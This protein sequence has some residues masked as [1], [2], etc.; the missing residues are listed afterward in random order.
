[1]KKVIKFKPKGM[2][3]DLSKANFSPEFS[4]ENKNIR[5]TTN[6]ANSLM[7]ITNE[8]G[9]LKITVKDTTDTEVSFGTIIGS[10]VINNELILFY[11]NSGYDYI[12]VLEKEDDAN[13]TL[14]KSFKGKLGFD[15]AYPI[16]TISVYE[17]NNTQKIYWTDGFNQPRVI[18]IKEGVEGDNP[19]SSEEIDF[20]PAISF[21]EKVKIANIGS[22]GS[23]PAGTIQYAFTYYNKNGAESNIVYISPLQYI[24]HKNRGASAED[25]VDTSFNIEIVDDTPSKYDYVR[26]YSIHRTSINSTPMCKRVIDLKIHNSPFWEKQEEKTVDTNRHVITV[27]KISFISKSDKEYKM[28]DYFEYTDI[29]EL[30]DQTILLG[31]EGEDKY[32]LK[33]ITF[34]KEEEGN[35]KISFTDLSNVASIEVFSTF[36]IKLM[37]ENNEEAS[38]TETSYREKYK[39]SYTDKGDSGDSIDPMELLYV[40]GESVIA[41]TIS[42]K[43]NTLFLG[44][45]QKKNTSLDKE[46]LEEIR[47]DAETYPLEF[48]TFKSSKTTADD[49]YY[50]H[51]NTL[52]DDISKI[53]TFKQREWYRFGIQL[54]SKDGKWSNPIFLADA[55]NDKNIEYNLSYAYLIN[56]RWNLKSTF[57]STFKRSGY[58]RVR[59]V[60]VYP[61]INERECICQGV[62]APTVYNVDDRVSNSPFVQSSWVFRPN[63]EDFVY[64]NGIRSS[65]IHGNGLFTYSYF[66]DASIS[67]PNSIIN[68]DN[69]EIQACAYSPMFPQIAELNEIDNWITN[70][71]E[72]YFVDRSIFTM[73][74]PDLEFEDTLWNIDFSN[75]KFRIIGIV[76]IESNYSDINIET[77][78]LPL[79]VDDV[80]APGYVKLPMQVS[81]S[82]GDGGGGIVSTYSWRDGNS[83]DS[84]DTALKDYS[85]HLWHRSGSLNNAAKKDEDGYRSAELKKKKTSILRYSTHTK[86]LD[87]I[88]EPSN[89]ISG[90]SLYNNSELGLV[91]VPS[92]KN[93][94]LPDIIYYGN[95]DKIVNITKTDYKYHNIEYDY[96]GNLITS[97]LYRVRN[98]G[99]P[100][101]YKDGPFNDDNFKGLDPVNIKYKSSPHAIIALNYSEDGGVNVL[102]YKYTA[103]HPKNAYNFWNK[104]TSK[105][106]SSNIEVPN[107]IKSYL[108]LGELYRDNIENRFGGTSEDALANNNWLP[109]GDPVLLDATNDLEIVWSVGDT[110]YQRYDCLKTYPFTFEDTNQLTDILSFMC[111]TRVN[112]DGRYDRNRGR[113]VNNTVTPSNFNLINPIY[114]QQDNFFNYR[115][116]EEETDNIYPNI[117]TWSKTK[118]FGEKVDTWTNITLASTLDLDGDKGPITALRRFNNQIIAFQH[119]GISHILYNENTQ[120]STESGVPIEIANSGKVSGKRYIS[121][122]VG[123]SNKQSICNSS[124]GLY[125][126]DSINK[127]INLFNG[128]SLSSLSRNLGFKSWIANHAN[129]NIWTKYDTLNNDILFIDQNTCL[130][131]S[132][133]LGQFT[134]FYDYNDVKSVLNVG[135]D[136]LLIKDN[137]LYNHNKGLYNNFFNSYKP[138][139]IE[140]IANENPTLD[141]IFTNI[142]FTSDTWNSN[143]DLLG[144]TFDTLTVHNEYQQGSADLLFTK[145]K[146]SPL[147][148]KFRIWRADIPRDS[149][150]NRDRMRNTWLNLKLEKSNADNNSDKTVLHDLS[151]YYHI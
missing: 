70:N 140:V 33:E 80:V 22:G 113:L 61:S 53:T 63:N 38:V 43:D 134:S 20:V 131:Y 83:A 68:P 26:I 35:L 62:V 138:F 150:N 17:N 34:V 86:Y 85:V 119:T 145:N 111:E 143:N 133:S 137:V 89:G 118:V 116:V 25:V 72:Y 120:I 41:Q 81:K 79:T 16:E 45:I 101:T 96:E 23:F 29:K 82:S 12:S 132:E 48:F 112:I 147:K 1:M 65:W 108:L 106:N 27:D 10:T 146:P 115:I 7:S 127:E 6:E 66:H 98:N 91:T 126:I 77:S 114:T 69:R 36:K 149:T 37:T 97:E 151:V 58:T 124:N 49:S 60:I 102:P 73:H 100:I 93:S 56:A 64:Y 8:K 5:F 128:E 92:P 59:P 39:T 54:Q 75:A 107:N 71:G 19:I 95:V 24:T 74:S 135:K 44:N 78:T 136:T 57:I 3:R 141:K 105:I 30:V 103:P 42:H 104:E 109:C 32:D 123:C 110:F 47:K 52:K 31:S 9:P 88:W 84:D 76:P 13:Y 125:F 21:P 51:I 18:N 55:Q 90:A 4:Y 129:S 117:V 15:T 14:K 122:R 130:A 46:L 11:K 142:E 94:G 40:G 121:D 28:A 50:D 2:N 144:N 148:R 139:Y 67:Y 87:S 99:Y